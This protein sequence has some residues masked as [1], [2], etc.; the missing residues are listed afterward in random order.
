MKL[1]IS[2]EFR[3][4]FPEAKIG[5]IEAYG[6]N[7]RNYSQPLGKSSIA[8]LLK[9]ACADSA[10]F[11][12]LEPLSANPAVGVWR[13]AFKKFKTKKGARSSIEAMLSR[14]KKGNPPRAINPLV[15]IYNA[16]SLSFGFPC[17][18]EDLDTI[19]GTMRLTLAKGGEAFVGIGERERDDCL[20]GEVA[21]LDDLGAVC[22]SWN[23]RDGQRTMLT[24]KT[25]NA[26][27]VIECVDPSRSSEF[28]DALS[29]LADWVETYLGGKTRVAYA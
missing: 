6:I 17:G 25:V 26:I 22:R 7:N 20:P 11:T 28:E 2:P 21:Y 13:E 16:V 29:C 14:V 5:V 24:E 18:G 12:S 9:K 27:L 19:K 1:I 23:W 8:S 4:L 10:R 15:D 3:G